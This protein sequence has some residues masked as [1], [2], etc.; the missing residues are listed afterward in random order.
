[1]TPM[2]RPAIAIALFVVFAGACLPASTQGKV[3]Q[4]FSPRKVTVN[5]PAA[6][7]GRGVRRIRQVAV[8]TRRFSRA[9]APHTTKMLFFPD[10]EL[11]IRWSAVERVQQPAGLV[12]TGKVEGIAESQATLALSGKT[13]TG[14]I[15]PGKG[16]QYQIRTAIDG[17]YWVREVD[18]GELPRESEPLSPRRP[19]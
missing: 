7:Q 9:E 10:V 18:P 8:D 12:W 19:E 15:N 1:M 6:M 13:M 17:G 14:N 11:V 2:M 5:P 3:P 4:V 16:L